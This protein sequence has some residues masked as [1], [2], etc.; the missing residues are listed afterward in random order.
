MAKGGCRS[1][2]KWAP[3]TDWVGRGLSK[4]VLLSNDVWYC[5]PADLTNLGVLVSSF[6]RK[7][8]QGK[9]RYTVEGKNSQGTCVA[10]LFLLPPITHPEPSLLN[11]C[12]GRQ[13]GKRCTLQ[14]LF[15]VRALCLVAPVLPRLIFTII[16]HGSRCLSHFVDE[17]CIYYRN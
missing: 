15:P 5:Y 6:S 14:N 4:T 13:G 3:T 17:T 8:W 1:V 16:L 9:R 12:W 7:W 11:C 2:E 10:G